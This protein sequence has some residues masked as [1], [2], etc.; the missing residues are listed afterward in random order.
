MPVTAAVQAE[1]LPGDANPLEVLRRREHLLDEIAILV[2]EPL[3]LHQGTLCLGDAVGEPVPDSLQLAQVEHPRR[4]SHSI[5]SMRNLGATEAVAEAGGELSLKPGDL[6]PQ[7]Q[8]GLALVDRCAYSG[9]SLF[10]Q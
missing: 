6:P 3:P 8:T 4:D 1:V 5:N 10:S 7:L 9:K 2:L